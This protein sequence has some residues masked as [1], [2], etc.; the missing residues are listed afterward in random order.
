M[1]ILTVKLKNG[2]IIRIEMGDND[3]PIKTLKENGIK[4]TTKYQLL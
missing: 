4:T 2:H 1:K 3:C